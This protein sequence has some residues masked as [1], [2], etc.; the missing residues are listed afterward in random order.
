MTVFLNGQFVPEAA[1]TVSVFDRGFLYGDGLF[2]TMRVANGRIFLLE[3]HLDRLERGA[4]FLGIV[5]PFP[6]AELARAAAELVR[7]NGLADALLRLTVSRGVGPRGYSPRGA[8]RPTV[9]MTAHPFTAAPELLRWR[10][11][12]A[13]FRLPAGDGLAAFKTVNKLA[14]V[15]ARAEAEAAGA[16]E[17]LLLDTAGNVIEAASG[18]LFWLGN[19]VL[20]TPPVKAGVLAGVTRGLIC[21]LAAASGLPVRETVCRPDELRGADGIFLTLSSHGVVEVAS[22]DGHPLPSAPETRRWWA[23]YRDAVTAGTT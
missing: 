22:V 15:L 16:E 14:Q 2:E 8:D 19:G 18:N 13:S 17:A 11:R 7:R 3:R 6:R 20:H 23:A 5:L 10:T 9:V 12:V 21:E 1:A 4:A